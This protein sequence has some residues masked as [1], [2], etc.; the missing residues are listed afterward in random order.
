SE[1]GWAC[2]WLLRCPTLRG[3]A[4]SSAAVTSGGTRILTAAGLPFGESTYATLHRH[5]PSA[6]VNGYLVKQVDHLP[7]CLTLQAI[8]F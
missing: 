8:A 7:R 5:T 1:S 2:L 4:F 3:G 6:F